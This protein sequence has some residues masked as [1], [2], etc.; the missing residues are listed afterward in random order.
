MRWRWTWRT[1]YVGRAVGEETTKGM[2]VLAKAQAGLRLGLLAVVLVTTL[3]TATFGGPIGVYLGLIAGILSVILCFDGLM[4]KLALQDWGVRCFLASF[5]LL[6]LAFI[7]SAP[8]GGDAMAFVD[9]LAL[10]V[11]VPL[12]ALVARYGGANRTVL[13]AVMAAVGC[14][15]ALAHGLYEV[16]VLGSGRAQ[17]NTSAIYFSNLSVLLGAFAL[18]GLVVVEK[19]WRWVFVAAFACAMGAAVLGG[20]RGSII[21]AGAVFLVFAVYMVFV[22]PRPLGVKLGVVVGTLALAVAALFLLFDMSRMITFFGAAT[23]VA[24]KQTTSDVSATI[25]LMLYNAAV[26]SFLDAPI[27]GHGWWQRFAAAMPY[28][29]GV[30]SSFALDNTQHLHN[31]VLNFASGAGVI[32]VVAYL[33]LMAGPVASAIASAKD[34]GRPLRIAIATSLT[35]AYVAMGLTDTMFVFETPKSIYVLSAAIVMAFFL[36][37]RPVP[38]ST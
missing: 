7:L 12:F 11:V 21:T 15:A 17:G 18:W 14:L 8:A 31:D 34:S 10:P 4:L 23:D 26:H 28:M 2:G 38:K 32:G 27:F 22:W 9:F 6:E 3:V 5:L 35:A 19:W 29:T 36:E 24:A 1:V 30:D 33:I 20:T 25:R 37:A 16:K 13:F